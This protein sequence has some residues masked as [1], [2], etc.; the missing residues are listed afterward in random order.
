MFS[1]REIWDAIEALARSNGLS[2]SALAVRAGLDSTA[3]NR[4][5]RAG[6]EGKLRWPSTETLAKLLSACDM[7]FGEF[8]RGIEQARAA[9]A[10]HRGTILFVDD[11]ADFCRA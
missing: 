8:C 2:L 3:L 7:P 5:K 9:R 10:A 1:Q 6:L 11:D 4:S